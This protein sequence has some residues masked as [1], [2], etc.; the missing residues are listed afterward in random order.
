MNKII[1]VFALVLCLLVPNMLSAREP[2]DHTINWLTFDQGQKK[3]QAQKQKFFLYFY[4]DW[5]GY[6]RKLEKETFTNKDVAKFI[7]ANFIPVRINSDRLPKV[8]ARFQ[9]QGFP[10]MKFLTPKG[11]DIGSLPGYLDANQLLPM[12]QYIG[13]DSYLKMSFKQFLSR[14]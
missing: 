4:A 3:G 8:T 7:N 2:I 9:V 5:C 13:S 12:L 14:K 10:H 11:E 6:C 1:S